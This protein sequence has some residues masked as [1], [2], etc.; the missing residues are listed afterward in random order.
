MLILLNV[1]QQNQNNNNVEKPVREQIK[2]F[3]SVE[4]L[5]QKTVG[6]QDKTYEFSLNMQILELVVIR[7]YII[8]TLVHLSEVRDLCIGVCFSP[9]FKG[10]SSLLGHFP[11]FES[12]FEVEQKKTTTKRL[13][14]T[15]WALQSNRKVTYS[16]KQTYIGS[17]SAMKY[18]L[19]NTNNFFSLPKS[20][21]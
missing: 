18:H 2:R 20:L 21:L 19:S 6:E 8:S 1:F 5:V 11:H 16:F 4:N 9:N 14:Q 13:S 17:H 10:D 15:F 12:E 3:Y 7:Y